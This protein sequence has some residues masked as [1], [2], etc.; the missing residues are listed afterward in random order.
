[1]KPGNI[2]TGLEV[3]LAD[4]SASLA[5]ARLGLLLNQASL[6]RRF[7]YAH[8]LL[9]ERFAGRLTALFSPQHGL[10]GQQQANMIETP[11]GLDDDLRIPVYSLYSDTRKPTCDM[12]RG[13]DA[14]LVDLQDVGTRIYTFI[15]TVSHCLEACAEANVRVVI[16]DRP[17]PLGGMVA[18]GPR[19]DPAFASFV[20][21][22][23][24]PMRHGLTLGELALYV[25]NALQIGGQLEV[26]PMRGW[27]REMGFADTG[28]SWTAPS[29]NLPRLEGVQLYP[30]MVLLEGTNLSEG[31]GT[32]TPF[33]VVGAPFIDPGK[34]AAALKKYDL[35]GMAIRPIRFQ[36][37][38]DK[39]QGQSCGGVYI[40]ITDWRLVRSYRLAVI[41]LAA[42]RS[43]WPDDLHWLPPPYEYEQEKMPIDILS[44]SADLREAIDNELPLSATTIETLTAPPA[45]WWHKVQ[46]YL[47]Y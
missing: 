46:P 5:G 2:Q 32:T 23:A 17:N 41:L 47:Q 13:L 39:W 20:G 33:E 15:W 22:A 35:P 4:P 1:M 27:R 21:R 30:G 28:L 42:V 40:H 10:W 45:N 9:A 24:I 11:H 26:I 43:L 34:L 7:R 6:D 29:P 19:L 16:L 3:L 14:L 31:R 44:G 25:N 8:H 36:P 18:E 37:T 38:F 12:L